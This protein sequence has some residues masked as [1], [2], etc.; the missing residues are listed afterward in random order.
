MSAAAT[1]LL[2]LAA[3]ATRGDWAVNRNGPG[4]RQIGVKLGK[5]RQAQHSEV[6]YTVGLADDREDRANAAFI[7]AACPS[8]LTAILTELLSTNERLKKERDAAIEE[9]TSMRRR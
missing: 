9:L 1:K 7:V 8:R 4:C 3:K 5:H 6:A 2:A